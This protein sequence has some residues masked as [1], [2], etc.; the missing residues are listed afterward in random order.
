MLGRCCSSMPVKSSD[1]DPCSSG[2]AGLVGGAGEMRDRKPWLVRPALRQIG[3]PFR[4]RFAGF[5]RGRPTGRRT[6]RPAPTATTWRSRSRGWQGP[7]SPIPPRCGRGR[8]PG[9]SQRESV[10]EVVTVGAGL[11][12]ELHHRV[13]PR[14][15]LGDVRVVRHA[16]VSSAVSIVVTKTGFEWTLP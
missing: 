9:R 15:L 7:A 5:G 4:L 11:L 8:D 16:R 14:H 2:R 12:A 6:C 13:R 10:N 1:E 3:Q